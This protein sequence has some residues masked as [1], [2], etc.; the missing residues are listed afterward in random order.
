MTHTLTS[1]DITILEHIFYVAEKSAKTIQFCFKKGKHQSYI[2]PKKDIYVTFELSSPI[3][4]DY[5]VSDLQTFLATAN[6]KLDFHKNNMNVNFLE[7]LAN[8]Q[9]DK[10][11]KT[12]IV[13]ELNFNLDDFNNNKKFKKYKYLN[14]MGEGN[15]CLFRYQNHE[16]SWWYLDTDREDVNHSKCN[17]KFRYVIERSKL[18]LLPHNDYK[19]IL[20]HEVIQLQLKDLN[21]YFVPEIAWLRQ[22]VK[23]WTDE[24][25]LIDD[26]H[27]I[28]QYIKKGYISIPQV[29]DKTELNI[30]PYDKDLSVVSDYLDDYNFTKVKTKYTKGD[31]WTAVSL[32]GYG[33]N[34]EDILKPNVL[35]SKV[36]IDANLQWTSF[37]TARELKPIFKILDTLSCDFERVRF[38]KLSANKIIGKHT[39]KVDKDIANKKIVRLHIPIRTNDNVVFKT[40]DNA[41]DKTGHKLNLKTGH[42]YYIDVSKPH[43]VSNNSDVDRYHLVV[44]CFVNDNLRLLL[45]WSDT[46]KHANEKDYDKVN[47]IFQPYKKDYFPHLRKDYLQRMIKTGNVVLDKEVVITYNPYKRK[48]TLSEGVIAEKGDCV[49]HQIA[50]KNHDGSA[51]DVLQRFF[52][53][54]NARVFLTVRSSNAVAKK[55]YEKNGMKLVGHTSWSKGTLLGDI[56]MHE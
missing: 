51:S 16:R 18:R 26:E 41:K 47:M 6:T 17:R 12:K 56:Y 5:A 32:H 54:V 33:K 35:K 38:M 53:F 15:K 2:T 28:K 45:G 1:R 37:S 8:E 22:S 24:G 49:L 10:D 39:D 31:D 21:Y 48:N 29:E 4:F 43:S 25:S 20:R 19:L 23:D 13:Q 52:K 11:F 46:I 44:D 27:L 50:S 9:D 30:K 40:Y 7:L 3:A 34:A 14:I 36:K 42:Y 55:F